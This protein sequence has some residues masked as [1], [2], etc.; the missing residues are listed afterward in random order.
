MVDR[1]QVNMAAEAFKSQFA[2]N[3]K[4][5]ENLYWMFLC[6]WFLANVRR[7]PND[8]ELLYFLQWMGITTQTTLFLTEAD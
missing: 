5:D 4:A 6:G 1:N 7:I 8:D 2:S 3:K